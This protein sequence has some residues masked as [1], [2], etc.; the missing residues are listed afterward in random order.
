[1]LINNSKATQKQ[2]TI[3][4]NLSSISNTS[5]WAERSWIKSGLFNLA[6]KRICFSK[7]SFCT[8][9]SEK[10]RWKSRPHGPIATH[11]N[12]WAMF[13]NSNQLFGSSTI[14]FESCGWIPVQ[15]MLNRLIY[16][17]MIIKRIRIMLPAVE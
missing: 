6:A 12:D 1:M 7:I 3:Q 13:S 4:T 15:P 9:G 17:T 8:S 11:S 14:D 16:I 2:V 10:S 5:T